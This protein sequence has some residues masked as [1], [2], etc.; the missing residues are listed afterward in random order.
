VRGGHVTIRFDHAPHL[1]Q[2]RRGKQLRCVSCHSQIVQ[3]QHIVVTLDTCFLCHFK[4][5]E[6][7]R[8]EETL[9]GCKAC[10]GSP[11]SAVRL[12]TGDFEHAQYVDRGVAC[13]NCHA[14]VVKGDGAVPR[15]TCWNCHNQQEQIGKYGQTNLLHQQH[16]SEHKVE[17]SSCHIKIEHNLSAAA[18]LAIGTDQKP[19]PGDTCA[20][21]HEKMHGGPVEM[22]RGVGGRGVPD[23]PSPMSRARVSCIACH[24]SQKQGGGDAQFT[25][26]TFLAVQQSCD[27]CHGN[28]YEGVLEQWKSI[29]AT[30]LADTEAVLAEARKA[31]DAAYALT[32]EDKL[33]VARLLDDADYNVRFVKLGHGVHNVNYATALLST[34]RERCE[35]A[36]QIMGGRP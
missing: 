30:R 29:V 20:Q 24:K 33:R 4:G 13:E 17:C 22:Y 14:D 27:G 5:F 12:P 1:Q 19:R 8:H 7:G 3:G 31:A 9:G 11:K 35:R 28:K 34:A 15:Q 32:S 2:E 26:Q 21:C 18:G 23:M 25:G 6:H 36:T 16:V 10:H